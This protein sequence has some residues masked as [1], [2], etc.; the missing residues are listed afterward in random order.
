MIGMSL[1]PLAILLSLRCAPC[2]LDV[3]FEKGMPLPYV[4]ES[5]DLQ[6]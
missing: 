4:S 6:R 3:C 5:D 1:S 2:A